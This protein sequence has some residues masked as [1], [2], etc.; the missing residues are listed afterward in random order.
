MPEAPPSVT[1]LRSRTGETILPVTL[2]GKSGAVDTYA[3][4]D[5]GSSATLL[6]K[7]IADELGVDGKA[8]SLCMQWTSGIDKKVPSTQ[9]AKLSISE[10][11]SQR[12]FQLS[13]IYTVE[14]LKLPEQSINLDKL[15]KQYKHLQRL[16]VKSFE[17]ANPGLLIGLSNNHLLTTFK[18][19]EGKEQEPIAV[20]TRI[21]WVVC[22]SLRGAESQ[23]QHRQMHI[24]AETT[25]L[26][27]HNY[28]EEFFSVESLGVAVVPN[29]EGLEDQRARRI[30]QETTV[31]K[32]NGRFETG[33]L[34]KQDDI[35][36]PDSRPM[37]ER[38]LKC[39][40]RRLAQNSLLYDSVFQ[41]IADYQ[42][43]G[44]VHAVTEEEMSSFDPRRIWYL[45]LGVVLNPNKPGKV[46]VIWDAAA[47]VNGVSLN[48][49]LLKGLDLLT[50]QLTVTFKFRERA[51]A[52]SGDIQEMFLQVGIRRQDRSAL[53][54][55]FRNSPS[56]PMVTMAS[57]VAIFGACSPCQSQYV[58]HL[59]ASNHE[60][61]YPKAAAAIKNRHYV[62]DYLDSVDTEEEGVQ[63]AL[64]VAKVHQKAGFHIRNW[65]S[66]K[67]NVLEAIGEV[68][69]ATVKH[70]TMNSQS[71]F[72]RLLGI[73]WIPGEDAFCFNLS[74]K[75]DLEELAKGERAPTKR[76]MLSLLM[77]IYDPLGLV[78][79]LVIQGKILLQDVWREKV[80]W[81]EQIPDDIFVRWKLWLQALKDL[82][83]IKIQRCY[84]PGYNPDSY[85]SLELHIFVDGSAQ[86]YSAAAYFRIRDKGQIR[87]ALVA[88][89]T[90]VA[91]LQLLSIPRIELQA[92]IIGARLRRTIVEGHSVKVK[93]TCFWGDS[94]NVIS[95]IRS[96]TR[97]YRQY[98]AFRV[99]EIQSLS[100]GEEWR[101]L[102]TNKNVAD[103]ATNWGK[104]PNCKPDS[105]WMRGPAFLYEEEN[106][107]PKDKSD[108]VDETK[109]ELRPAF[110]F[111]HPVT[112][113]VVDVG[114]LSKYER[115]LRSIAYVHQF[116]DIALRRAR[117]DCRSSAGVLSSEALQKSERNLWR[118]A[119]TDQYPDEVATMMRNAEVE[120]D[121]RKALD[122]DS[123]IAKLPPRIDEHGVLRFDSRIAAAEF[124]SYDTRYPIILPRQHQITQLVLDWYHRHMEL[125]YSLTTESCKKAIRRFIARRGAPQEIFTDNGTN[126]VGASRELQKEIHAINTTM[127]S[128]FTDVNTIWRFKP[129]AA[130]HMGGCWERMVRS[131]KTAL[132]SL[133]TARK[134]DD[135][136]LMTLLAGAEHIVNS[137]RLT[138]VPLNK[139]QQ[140]SI[141]PNHFLMQSSSG[142]RQAVKAPVD[143]KKALS[144]G[145]ALVQH[146]LDV[147]WRRWMEASG[148][149]MSLQ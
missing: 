93:R 114:R 52:I 85:E 5:D 25:D 22:G 71:G 123:S 53:L 1:A 13:E 80:N 62:D 104:G 37:A 117:G 2:Y 77:R 29:L 23:L 101:W 118:M 128:T 100:T 16:P 79:S 15:A 116:C 145:W 51:V 89:K 87:C 72:E 94:S 44:D 69:P 66:N 83:K 143:T 59:N 39:L 146:M 33:L 127:S 110:I 137:R 21:G 55:V 135:E 125:A 90:K 76:M 98:V 3:F 120:E 60:E 86:A 54:F 41:Q 57:D 45:P 48:T 99:N 65:V 78:G 108:A 17:R 24:C 81:D 64:E 18:V 134:L 4:L 38:R 149:R 67:P 91:P 105:R 142:V 122:K 74:L 141:T 147:F 132:G 12:M 140:E 32:A 115:L 36:F 58:K 129:P 47:K 95:W 56:E 8:L 138:F 111:S 97:R 35:D 75:G 107:W 92:E 46:R 148:S 68:K 119:Q 70:L 9:I 19:R 7:A 31:Q 96:D 73:S 30:L 112:V 106:S 43:K 40:E 49:M 50:P 42:S 20:K 121:Q 139:E 14:N 144:D 133:P 126:F 130:P 88:S 26:D 10:P 27:L 82:D 6:R 84:F 131:V 113:P 102:G 28:V 34:W 63:L 136:G 124:V 103:E 11:G 61:E 109:E